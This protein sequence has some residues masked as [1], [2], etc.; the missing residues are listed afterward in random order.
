MG[1]NRFNTSILTFSAIAG[2]TLIYLI[3]KNMQIT[4]HFY[5]KEISSSDTAKRLGIKNKPNLDQFRNALRLAREVLEPTRKELKKPMFVSS[6]FRSPALNNAVGGSSSSLHLQAN[7]VDVTTFGDNGDIWKALLRSG[8]PF[9]ELIIEFNTLDNPKW[10]HI[11]YN[12]RNERKIL[13]AENING[14]ITYR[15]LNENDLGVI[16]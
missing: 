6:W 12:G 5:E 14:A 4:K 1:E 16:A 9:T 7:A 2:V 8:A 13:R 11:G 3:Q 15:R 10:V